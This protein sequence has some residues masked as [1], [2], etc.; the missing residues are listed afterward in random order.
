[1][2]MRANIKNIRTGEV[3]CKS[4]D[5]LANP[6]TRSMG[7]MGKTKTKGALFKLNK[8]SRVNAAI[9]MGMMLMPI[10]VIWMDKNG[11]VVDIRRNIKPFSIIDA[12]TWKTYV[13]KKKAG[14]ILELEA[15]KVKGTK[16]GD[17][18]SIKYLD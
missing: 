4:A 5:V 11:V 13:P 10:D 15:G 16:A 9:H 12:R 18:L 7:L 14:F 8:E 17:V 6:V 2:N 3:V 1:M